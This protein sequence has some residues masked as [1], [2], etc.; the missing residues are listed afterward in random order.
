MNEGDTIS[1]ESSNLDKPR[2]CNLFLKVSLL[3][4]K[5]RHKACHF[6]RRGSLSK[7]S[8]QHHGMMDTRPMMRALG[9][10]WGQNRS[11]CQGRVGPRNLMVGDAHTHSE[12][13]IQRNLMEKQACPLCADSQG[14]PQGESHNAEET[15]YGTVCRICFCFG[16]NSA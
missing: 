13:W 3:E 1:T 4:K 16:S 14:V 7:W 5:L 9:V 2:L 8:L 15:S 12:G 11:V 6:Q 10:G